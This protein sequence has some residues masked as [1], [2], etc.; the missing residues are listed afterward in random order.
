MRQYW[1]DLQ[2]WESEEDSVL[3]LTRWCFGFYFKHQKDKTI[4]WTD[5]QNLRKKDHLFLTTQLHW[6]HTCRMKFCQIVLVTFIIY[7]SLWDLFAHKK[8]CYHTHVTII[9]F[10]FKWPYSCNTRNTQFESSIDSSCFLFQSLWNYLNTICLHRQRSYDPH[11]MISVVFVKNFWRFLPVYIRH[12]SG[13]LKRK[14]E[15]KTHCF[16]SFFLYCYF[17]NFFNIIT[18]ITVSKQKL[19]LVSNQRNQ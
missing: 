6:P 8:G 14:K 18:R 1:W 7:I 19:L 3:V 17:I 9:P 13:W 2:K 11:F 16:N 12:M 15:K 4:G 10:Y 5:V